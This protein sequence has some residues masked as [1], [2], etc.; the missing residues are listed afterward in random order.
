M[1]RGVSAFH[2]RIL[3]ALSINADIVLRQVSIV[4]RLSLFALVW[5]L[6]NICV[7]KCD[8]ETM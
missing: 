4:F 5:C 8:Y 7:I 2:L 6:L 1:L 3:V